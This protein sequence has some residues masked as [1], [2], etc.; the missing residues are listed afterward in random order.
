MLRVTDK[1][2]D[3]VVLV[4]QNSIRLCDVR[5]SSDK[6]ELAGSGG[7]KNFGSLSSQ[8]S[9]E[10]STASSVVCGDIWSGCVASA[11][12]T[13][14]MNPFVVFVEPR[15][16]SPPHEMILGPFTHSFKDRIPSP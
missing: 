15:R 10:T 8:M 3:Q 6:D 5:F 1:H 7:G 4:L 13:A 16:S 9:V 2:N 12:T 14:Q 11:S